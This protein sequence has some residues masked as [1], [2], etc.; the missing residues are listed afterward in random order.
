MVTRLSLLL[1]WSAVLL[2]L[3]CPALSSTTTISNVIPRRDTTGAIINA[4]A[5]GIYNFSGVFYLIGEHYRYCAH[6]GA[7]KTRDPLAVGDCEMC[8][9]T[10]TTFA[11]YTS[12]DLSKWTLNSTNVIPN[13]PGGQGANLYTPVLAYNAKFT[14]YIMLFQCSGGCSD[15]QLQVSTASTPAGPFTPRG[16]VL[17]SSD[18]RA[19]SSQGGIWVDE[20]TGIGYLIFNSIGNGK[21]NGQWIVELDE[22]Y[23]HITNKSAQIL[24]AATGSEGGWLEGGGIFKRGSLY[25]YMAGSGCCYCAGG[26][27]AMVFVATQPLGP[28]KFQTNVNPGLYLPFSPSGP[29]LPP[30]PVPAPAPS[31]L[32]D[33]LSGEW[34]SSVLVPNYQPLRAGLMVKKIPPPLSSS[35]TTKDYYNM[36]STTETHWPAV[37]GWM[38]E[39]DRITKT[40]NITTSS[41]GAMTGSLKPWLNPWANGQKLAPAPYCTMIPGDGTSSFHREFL[42]TM[43]KL[44]YCGESIRPVAAQQF[45]VLSL[46]GH[47]LYYG[48]R[49][50]STLSGLKAE[51]FSY[52]EPL[53]FDAEGV[54]QR[55]KFTDN[56]ELPL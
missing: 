42:P 31:T 53:R 38:L 28:W 48:E 37:H 9:H 27:G 41:H 55:M 51:D 44:P 34:A 36:T 5:G 20:S 7:N 23:L 6:A 12:T 21:Q 16:A 14:Y 49:W 2:S 18:P 39:V 13:K 30:P 1:Q 56:F 52:L 43:C 10:G 24:H 25:Y 47:V 33:D 46:G 54:M 32:C 3:A 15:G 50:Q 22:T 45:N 40:V 26:G 4:H 17:P 11:L 35:A 19:G 8:G 29:P